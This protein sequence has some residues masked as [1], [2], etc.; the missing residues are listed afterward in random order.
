MP[1]SPRLSRAVHAALTNALAGVLPGVDLDRAEPIGEGWGAAAFR[2][3]AAGHDMRGDWVLRIPRD[4]VPWAADDLARETQTL[5]LLTERPFEVGVPQ[6]AHLVRS[7][8]GVILGAIHRLVPGSPTGTYS[9]RGTA[10]REHLAGLGRFLATLHTTPASLARQ[11][12]VETRDMWREVSR[13]RIEATI[14]VAGEATRRWLREQIEAFEMLDLASVPSVLIHGDISPENLLTD[15]RGHLCGVIDFAEARLSDPA[16]D[17]AGIL[18]RFKWRDLEVVLANYD[19]PVDATLLERTRIYIAISPVYSVTD[20]YVAL[21][22]GERIAGLRRLAARA[23]RE[24]RNKSVHL[25]VPP[26]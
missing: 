8:E 1:D 6:E 26:S 11:Y 3:P 18:H 13:P 22:T 4:G 10:R 25:V 20:G 15:S 12:G 23:A 16:L 19:A 9:L 7:S 21:G 17:F 24:T 2:I 5:P 14:E